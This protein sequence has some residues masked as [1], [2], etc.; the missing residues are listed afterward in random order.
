MKTSFQ[1]VKTSIVRMSIPMVHTVPIAMAP[2]FT[3]DEASVGGGF[4]GGDSSEEEIIYS[5]IYLFQKHIV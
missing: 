2:T 1:P 5:S 3:A 4:S